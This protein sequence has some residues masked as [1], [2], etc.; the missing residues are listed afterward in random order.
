[1]KK[2]LALIVLLLLLALFLSPGSKDE[3]FQQDMSESG[4]DV[5]R[6]GQ[7]DQDKEYYIQPELSTTETVF[8][9]G[10]GN[11]RSCSNR[12][13]HPMFE[14]AKELGMDIPEKQASR[15]YTDRQNKNRFFSFLFGD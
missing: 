13:L 4:T 2:I 7:G 1:M 6:F 10:M 8:C 3:V 15:K 11:T 14:N 9:K 12:P 5:T